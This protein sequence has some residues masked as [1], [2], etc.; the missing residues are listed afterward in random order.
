MQSKFTFPEQQQ[1]TT[2]ASTSIH[3]PQHHPQI[4]GG[5]KIIYQKITKY[6]T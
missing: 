3:Q 5:R 4:A 2:I 6:F 1:P